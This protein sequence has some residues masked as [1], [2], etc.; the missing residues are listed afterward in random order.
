MGYA[1]FLCSFLLIQVRLTFTV[2]NSW[3][4]KILNPILLCFAYPLI[5]KISARTKPHVGGI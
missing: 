5:E 2:V 1:G 4:N 3:E